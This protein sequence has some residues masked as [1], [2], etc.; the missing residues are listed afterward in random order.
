MPY[1]ILSVIAAYLIGSIPT[2]YIFGRMLKG[3]DIREYGSGNVGATNVARVIGKG[4]GIVVFI[5]DFLKGFS[6]VALIPLAFNRIAPDAIEA[7]SN[8]IFILA[9]AAAIAGHIWTVF[10][11]FKGGKGVST[12]LGVMAALSPAIFLGCI[13]VWVV[14]FSVWRYVSLASISVAV[15]LPILAVFMNESLSFIMFC[16]ALCLVSVYAHR[17][18]IKRLI[19]GTESRI[20]KGGKS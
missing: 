8:Y 1:V 6:A 19:Q 20:V 17:S 13:L 12:T 11:K 9:G 15:S 18:N 16:A 2:A 14:V 5:I 4:P 7:A 3:V 10:L